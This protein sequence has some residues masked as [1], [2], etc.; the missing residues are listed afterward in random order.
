[1]IFSPQI[2]LA[3][4]VLEMADIFQKAVFL[5]Y[6]VCFFSETFKKMVTNHDQFLFFDVSHELHEAI[7]GGAVP[8]PKKT[9]AWNRGAMIAVAD[10]WYLGKQKLGIDGECEKSW[11]ILISR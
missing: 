5:V 8:S 4:G 2:A 7:H 6:A 1:M 10:P 3:I 11:H 9:N